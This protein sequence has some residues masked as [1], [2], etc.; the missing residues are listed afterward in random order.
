MEVINPPEEILD[1]IIK[2]RDNLRRLDYWE[3]YTFLNWL[4]LA[5]NPGATDAQLQ[6]VVEGHLAIRRII[7]A[8]YRVF[9]TWSRVRDWLEQPNAELGEALPIDVLATADGGSQVESLITR[10]AELLS[11][12]Q[13]RSVAMAHVETEPSSAEIIEEIQAMIAGRR[14]AAE[15]E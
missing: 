7:A 1:R 8:A 11:L 6:A 4:Y 10:M 3:R 13:R 2:G 14:I 5:Y 12:E 15:F 9:G